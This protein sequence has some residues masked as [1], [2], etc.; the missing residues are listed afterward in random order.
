[1]QQVITDKITLKEYSN[2]KR[3]VNFRPLVFFTLFFILGISI[4]RNSVY[5]ADITL[6]F[7]LFALSSFAFAFTVISKH[8]K[9]AWCLFGLA[10]GFARFIINFSLGDVLDF[11][12]TSISNFFLP[13]KEALVS[14]TFSL[15]PEKAAGTISAILWGHKDSLSPLDISAFRGAG[16]SHILAL[17]GLHVSLFVTLFD[18]LFPRYMRKEKLVFC[19]IFLIIYCSIAA[20]PPSLIRASIMITIYLVSSAYFVHYDGLTS[21]ALAAFIILFISPSEIEN[22]SFQ[23]SFSAILGIS[24]VYKPIH[25]RLK[26]LIPRYFAS[27]IAVTISAT[28]GVLPVSL[29]N[30]GTFA[31]YSLIGNLI[32]LPFVT[33][34]VFSSFPCVLLSFLL[35]K[36]ASALSMVISF[37]YDI[38]FKISDFI[39]SLPFASLEMSI[40]LPVSVC[41]FAA[42]FVVSQYYLRPQIFK[43][44]VLTFISILALLSVLVI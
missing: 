22:L 24:L 18:K 30:F 31:T 35:P 14:Q 16:L 19:V 34:L 8:K 37:I 39:A 6:P 17:S 38:I 29:N 7:L 21:I 44:I 20:F 13:L 25:I 42:M 4:S 11:Y 3:P 9:L 40:P 28:L 23:M 43:L 32:V 1:M 5:F 15:F 12:L 10:F 36:V 2:E 26:K 33:I 41:L 27:S